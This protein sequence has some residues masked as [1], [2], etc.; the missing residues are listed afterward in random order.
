MTNVREMAGDGIAEPGERTSVIKPYVM[1]HGTLE[2]RN[3]YRSR[4]FY[5]D[6][7][8]LECAVHS[9]S[10]MAIWCGLKFHIVAV[11]VGDSIH[12]VSLLNH[13]GI[14]LTSREDVDQAYQD[15]LAAK[16]TY[17]LGEIKEP[18]DRH[19]VYSFYFQDFD[20]NWW[21]IQHYPGFINDDIFDF[22]DRY[23]LKD[24]EV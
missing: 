20:Y 6:F 4:R 17:G 14:D 2:C 10:S 23:E 15:V 12:P 8:G 9:P 24:A 3:L 1:S 13:W 16:A 7:L 21:E 18:L 11:E 5:E 22:G 19:G